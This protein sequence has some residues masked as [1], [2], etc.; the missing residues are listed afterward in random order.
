MRLCICINIFAL[1]A[2]Q[3]TCSTNAA[4]CLPSAQDVSVCYV[5]CEEKVKIHW[6]ADNS[7]NS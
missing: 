6:T 7:N 5:W 3:Y 4:A 2:I 1:V